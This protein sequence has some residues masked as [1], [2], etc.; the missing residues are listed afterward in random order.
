MTGLDFDADAYFGVGTARRIDRYGRTWVLDYVDVEAARTVRAEND[1]AADALFGMTEPGVDEANPGI[2]YNPDAGVEQLV[3]PMSWD[4]IGCSG[5]DKYFDHSGNGP[6]TQ[7][8]VVP[9]N[10]R[11]RKIVK[12]FDPSG[13]VCSGAMVDDFTV[14]TAA[15]CMTNTSGVEYNAT[16]FMV[17]SMENLDENTTGIFQADCDGVDDVQ[18]NPG[19]I[20]WDPFEVEEDYGL[21]HL[22]GTLHVGSFELSSASDSAINGPVDYVRGYP[23]STRSC[24]NNEVTN[25]ALTTDDTYNGAQMYSADGAVQATPT[26]WVKWNTSGALGVSGAPHFYCPNTGGCD[27]GHYITGVL[28][29]TS[30]SCSLD[31]AGDTYLNPPC[32]SGYTSGPKARDIETWVDNNL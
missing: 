26:G 30:L 19:F 32:A 22:N 15:H 7:S 14:L 24:T 20:D 10:E 16:S 8:T 12:I 3:I 4:T 1:A 6:I 17:C 25:D 5:V 29:T 23:G 21:L 13:L 31:A 9:M 2:E 27:N 28:S 11:Q 18:K